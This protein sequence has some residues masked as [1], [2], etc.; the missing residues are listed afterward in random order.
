MKPIRAIL[1]LIVLCFAALAGGTSGAYAEKRVALVIGNGN[2][3]KFAKL[4]NPVNDSESLRDAL[5]SINFDV[6]LS[7]N[8]DLDGFAEGLATFLKKARDADV[9]IVYYAGHAVQHD[10]KNYLIPVNGQAEDLDELDFRSE[11]VDQ[12]VRALQISKGIR[13]LILDACRNNPAEGRDVA[14]SRSIGDDQ[15]RSAEQG[16]SRQSEVGP[17]RLRNDRGLCDRGGSRRG[18]QRR[19]RAQPL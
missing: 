7:E 2:Y 8:V 11:P 17:P 9:A 4:A 13:I 1:A 5:K 18:G 3:A 12:V 14:L 6:V 15:S 16:G 19:R 10:G